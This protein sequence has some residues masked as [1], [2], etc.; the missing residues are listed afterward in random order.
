MGLLGARTWGYG[1]TRLFPV[2]VLDGCLSVGYGGFMK[3]SAP[4]PA[5]VFH[6]V[7]TEYAAGRQTVE[8]DGETVYS[9]ESAASVDTGL[10]LYLFAVNFGGEAK[11]PMPARVRRLRIWQQP[12][13]GG[14]YALVRDLQ[15]VR[16]DGDVPAF[17]DAVTKTCLF[18]SRL[19]AD[20]GPVTGPFARGTLL[21][22]R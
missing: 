18:G 10:P 12:A 6:V 1:E 15:P 5:D 2:H 11:Y 7:R 3:T 22:V 8:L 17:Y 16:T 9:A 19:F 4:V 14:A 13:E 21:L 20:V